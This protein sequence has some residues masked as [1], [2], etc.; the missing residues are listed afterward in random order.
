MR[1]MRLIV[2]RNSRIIT[3]SPN[4]A[5][6]GEESVSKTLPKMVT[7]IGKKTLA[8]RLEEQLVTKLIRTDR[9]L[10]KP[11]LRYHQTTS[12]AFHSLR[13]SIRV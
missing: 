4:E 5:L 1:T 13:Q 9:E 8:L 2:R 11:H 12:A 7:L 3:L 6:S 10:L